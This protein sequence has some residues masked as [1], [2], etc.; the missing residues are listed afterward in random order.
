LSAQE[1]LELGLVSK[2]VPANE[3]RATLALVAQQYA[4]APTKA[5]GL[6]KKV[7]NQSSH[8]SLE[9]MLE[10]EAVHQDE[11]A[12]SH[13]FVEGVTA[14]LQKRPANFQGK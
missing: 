12:Q 3:F 1:C 2:V 8:S 5:I 6:I 7:L 14:F 9:Q 10:L 13:D 11:A 4:K